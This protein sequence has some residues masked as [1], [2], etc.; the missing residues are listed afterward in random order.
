MPRV[1]RRRETHKGDEPEE[2]RG[3]RPPLEAAMRAIACRDQPS[4]P[5]NGDRT[6]FALKALRIVVSVNATSRRE[7][8]D[9]ARCLG[10]AAAGARVGP[11][12]HFVGHRPATSHTRRQRTLKTPK[13]LISETGK[14]V[15][16]SNVGTVGEL[17]S[18]RGPR[19]PRRP[20]GPRGPRGVRIDARRSGARTGSEFGVPPPP[21]RSPRHFRSLYRW[22]AGNARGGLWRERQLAPRAIA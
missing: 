16:A 13:P 19:A 5:A 14:K 15:G 9:A 8:P 10:P 6:H 1:L 22:F 4:A 20:R 7:P 17:C 3:L 18:W 11:H 21:Y 2:T 12:V